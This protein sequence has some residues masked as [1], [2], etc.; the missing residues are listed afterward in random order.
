LNTD[1]L[2]D[3]RPGALEAEIER[4]QLEL[5][6]IRQQ[7]AD[8]EKAFG[9]FVPRQFLN[10][11]SV[12]NV[13]DVRLGMQ[14]E[15]KMTI[16]FADIR[17]FTGLSE[18]MTPQEN[19][20]FLNSYLSQMEPMIVPFRGLVDKYIGDAIMALFPESSDD[21]VEA[22]LAMLERLHNYN[23]GRA[24]AG[25]MPIRIGIGV[26][27]GIVMLGTVGGLGRMEGTVI[28][29]AVNLA[30]RL[31]GMSKVYGVPLLISEH[32]LHSLDDPA[33]YCIRFLARNRVKGKQEAQ[34]VYEVFDADPPIMRAAKRRTKKRFEEALAFY[35]V[36]DI[37]RAR[38]R[39]A[40]CLEDA[41]GDAPAALYLAR[42]EEYLRNG[43]AEGVEENELNQTWSEEYSS[44]VAEIDSQ[45][46]SLLSQINAL[47]TAVREARIHDTVPILSVIQRDAQQQFAAE[48]LLMQESRYPFLPEH[49]HQHRRFQ[50]N[51]SRLSDEIGSE[52]EN[53]V[54]MV[55]RIKLLLMDWIISHSIKTD[56]HLG[57]HLKSRSGG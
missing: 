53:P 3:S 37:S 32:T 26:N 18:S 7:L 29:D 11:L 55:F 40:K 8:T 30:S 13:R 31:E 14:T 34:S 21:G 46:R 15:R 12:D 25:Y 41:P 56:R 57:H 47:A 17:N 22:A 43:H 50:E 2:T 42:C 39:L 49:L 4:L 24:R 54:Y 27:T 36:G 1:S 48:A 35:F 20:D 6:D 33:R 23:L 38:S 19:F 52:A 28:S 10:F 45:H 16:L 9:R 5:A 51:L 44:G